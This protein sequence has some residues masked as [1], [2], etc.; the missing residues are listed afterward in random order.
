MGKK[1]TIGV[2]SSPAAT[3]ADGHDHGT[4]EAALDVGSGY[5]E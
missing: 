5:L 4:P 3:F 2:M 1:P